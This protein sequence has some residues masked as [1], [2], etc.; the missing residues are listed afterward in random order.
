MAD[1]LAFYAR[2]HGT[3]VD[4]RADVSP[5]TMMNIIAGS[6]PV[7]AFV[8][9]DFGPSALGRALYLNFCLPALR[10]CMTSRNVATLTGT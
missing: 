2:R 1:L 6:L 8:A 9:M 10:A 4:E 5:E 7:R 3:P